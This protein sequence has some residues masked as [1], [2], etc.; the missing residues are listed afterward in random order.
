MNVFFVNPP[1][2]VSQPVR[3]QPYHH[4]SSGRTLFEI[5][6]RESENPTDYAEGSHSGQSRKYD[7]CMS[8]SGTWKLVKQYATSLFDR[9][10]SGRYVK[11][12]AAM[13]HVKFP[14]VMVMT[15]TAKPDVRLVTP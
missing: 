9:C 12:A 11:H 2:Y 13:I 5:M 15:R 7:L 14:R 4:T 10:S 8:R 6:T 1:I 3:V